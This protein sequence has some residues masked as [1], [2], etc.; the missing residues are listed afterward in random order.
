QGAFYLF[1]AVDGLDDSMAAAREIIDKANVG[2]APGTAFGAGG[3]GFL[4]LCFH[5]RLDQ[6]EEAAHRVAN[7]LNGS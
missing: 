7:W 2:L 3:E 6:I 4:R 5:R 1:F